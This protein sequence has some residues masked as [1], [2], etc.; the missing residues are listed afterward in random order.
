VIVQSVVDEVIKVS[1]DDGYIPIGA[2]VD[3]LIGYN[4]IHACLAI[5]K[6]LVCLDR[7]TIDNQLS[8]DKLCGQTIKVRSRRC[9]DQSIPFGGRIVR[10]DDI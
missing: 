1:V 8:R 5:H 6:V 4:V 9:I 10:L 7:W 3:I 2:G